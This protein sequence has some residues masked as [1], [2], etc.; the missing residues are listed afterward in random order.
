MS[1]NVAPDQSVYERFY[2]DPKYA[3]LR[4]RNYGVDLMS[5]GSKNNSVV[6]KKSGVSG[7]RVARL[8]V[9]YWALA[10][11]I[12]VMSF[13]AIAELVT[14][15]LAYILFVAITVVAAVATLIHVRKGK[16]TSIDEIAKKM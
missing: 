5:S 4:S 16:N 10:F 13:Y 7:K 9:T 12:V 8:F 3:I 11:M 1:L 2:S 15:N 14:L 6:E